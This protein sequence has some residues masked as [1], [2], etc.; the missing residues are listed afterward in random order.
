[1][2]AKGMTTHRKRRLPDDLKDAR[3]TIIRKEKTIERYKVYVA[4]LEAEIRKLKNNA[5]GTKDH[6]GLA[7]LM[8]RR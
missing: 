8:Q 5:Q 6:I 4:L 7:A 3:A 2:E 1:M